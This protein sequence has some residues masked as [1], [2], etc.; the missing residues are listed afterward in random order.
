MKKWFKIAC[1]SAGI[2]FLLAGTV[3]A[4]SDGYTVDDRGTVG[5]AADAGQYTAQYTGAV[6]G[7]R[8][9]LLVVRQN[10]PIND[11]SVLYV[12]QTTA[13]ENGRVS[14]SFIPR[15]VLSSDVLLSGVFPDGSASPLKLGEL[16]GRGVTLTGV[17]KSYKAKEA[18]TVSLYQTGLHDTPLMTVQTV[19]PPGDGSMTQSFSLDVVPAGT[20][21]IKITKAGHT[22]YWITG[23][24]VGEE[25][26]SIPEAVLL[27]GDITGDRIIDTVD[28]GQLVSASNY[29]KAA[30]AAKNPKTDLNSDGYINVVDLGVLISSKHYGKGSVT[31]PYI[32]IP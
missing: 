8:Y 17:V 15:V 32:K 7:G 21:D 27:C 1:L 22:D 2:V 13:D 24:P 9:A 23:I 26:L 4:A 14:F 20:Y 12:N 11:D 28:L 3:F 31:V 30:Q 25:N 5:Y 18:G 16:I 6:P 29:G 19:V 10:A